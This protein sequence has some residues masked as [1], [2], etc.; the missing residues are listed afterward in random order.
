MCDAK[1]AEI[2]LGVISDQKKALLAPLVYQLAHYNQRQDIS[3]WRLPDRQFENN[4]NHGRPV[5]ANAD[6]AGCGKEG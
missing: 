5:K 4:V 3:H 6:A 1:F 2:T